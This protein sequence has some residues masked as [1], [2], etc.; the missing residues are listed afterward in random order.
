MECPYVSICCIAY[1][2]EPFI[3][4]AI[5]GFNKKKTT[6]PYEI[7]ISDDC[8]RDDTRAIISEYRQKYPNLLRDVSPDHN[9]GMYDNFYHVLETANGKYIAL[10]DGDDFWT[11]VH[12][13][14]KQVDILEQNERLIGCFTDCMAVS[15][16]GRNILMK[17]RP[18]VSM[19]QSGNY[20]LRDFLKDNRTS[21]LSLVYRNNHQEELLCKLKNVKNDFLADWP[22]YI[23]LLTYGDMYYLSQVTCAYRQNPSS[24]THTT[25][26][27]ERVGRVKASRIICPKVADTLPE[28]YAD[29]AKDLRDTRWTWL[30]LMFAYKHEKRYL[31]MIGCLIIVC[32]VCPKSLW[33]AWKS[34]NR[35]KA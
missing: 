8:S 13:L 29:I 14:Q 24:V 35:K 25:W 34:R 26:R 10:C 12:K 27:N 1:N 6:F 19:E 3:K 28:E 2:H 16:D 18:T 11:D 15:E 17:K 32:L 30:P 7:I 20:G 33:N 5:E 22:L 21:T 4:G 31:P 23:F 9:L